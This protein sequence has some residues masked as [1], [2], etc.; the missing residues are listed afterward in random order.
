MIPFGFQKAV[1]QPAIC[2]LLERKRRH[3]GKQFVMSYKFKPYVPPSAQRAIGLRKTISDDGSV[4]VG[5]D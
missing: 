5:H 4:F 1:F 2:R 3:I